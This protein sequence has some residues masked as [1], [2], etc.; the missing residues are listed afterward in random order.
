MA[1]YGVALWF[2]I[3]SLS[4]AICHEHADGDADHS[5]G[6]GFFSPS[7]RLVSPC[8]DSELGP[9]CRHYHMVLFGIEITILPGCAALETGTLR[10]Q[11]GSAIGW[12]ADSV[13][14]QIAG[15]SHSQEL[16]LPAPANDGLAIPNVVSQDSLLVADFP[17]VPCAPA[18]PP[19][20][21]ILLI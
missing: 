1:N 11:Q 2:A 19:R 18:R 6:Y 13:T 4:P 16:D 17:A 21:G 14:G 20:S 12:A 9:K 5:H 3:L 7:P 8:T 15:T 10:A